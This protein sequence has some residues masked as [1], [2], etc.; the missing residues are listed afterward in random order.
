[1]DDA[2]GS[3]QPVNDA[4]SKL[5]NLPGIT[6]DECAIQT[7]PG[8]HDVIFS[9]EVKDDNG[10]PKK[11]WARAAAMGT[12]SEAKSLEENFLAAN[13]RLMPDANGGGHGGGN[14][15]SSTSTPMVMKPFT[16]T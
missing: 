4:L 2:S 6:V 14:G 16:N 11:V 9:A 3:G 5:R 15:G 7:V 8:T 12:P 1:M 13:R 10:G